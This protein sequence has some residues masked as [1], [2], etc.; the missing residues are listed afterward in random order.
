MRSIDEVGLLQPMTITPNDVLVCGGRRL[1][2]VRRLG[3]RT[4]NV[5]VR[6]GVSDAL[7]QLLTQQDE[8]AHPKPLTELKTAALT[9]RSSRS[10]GRMRR[11]GRRPVASGPMP[12]RAE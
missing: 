8:N 5:W 3:W 10:C 9:G 4:S 2:A 7:S 1:E 12:K 6:S 11:S